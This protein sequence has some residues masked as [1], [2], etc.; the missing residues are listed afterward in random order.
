M[1]EPGDRDEVA[2]GASRLHDGVA[3]VVPVDDKRGAVPQPRSEPCHQEGRYAWRILPPA[4]L[5][6]QHGRNMAMAGTRSIHTCT[7]TR[8][9]RLHLMMV[10]ARLS[11]L[12]AAATGASSMYRTFGFRGSFQPA[13]MGLILMRGCC[14]T[15]WD[16]VESEYPIRS[17]SHPSSARDKAPGLSTTNT[18]LAGGTAPYLRGRGRDCSFA[19]SAQCPPT[20]RLR[21]ASGGFG[22]DAL[23][24]KQSPPT[25]PP[26]QAATSQVCRSW[27]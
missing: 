5:S 11:A 26:G 25:I 21:R 18:M 3:K 19:E 1:Q 7:R 24:G 2:R 20:Q 8:P 10:M 23:P 17:T 15:F 27:S 4:R 16:G 6:R 14:S 12:L 9:F 13:D 22:P